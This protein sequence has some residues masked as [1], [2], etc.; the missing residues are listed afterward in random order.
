MR[1]VRA[2]VFPPKAERYIRRPR[3]VLSGGRLDSRRWLQPSRERP[4]SRERVLVGARPVDRRDR[5]VELAQVHRQLT[6][7][8]IPVVEHDRAQERDR[9]ASRRARARRSSCRQFRISVRVVHAAERRLRVGDALVER[10]H[11][12]PPRSPGSDRAELRRL[13]PARA[14][15]ASWRRAP[16]TIA[17]CSASSPSVR[18]LACGRQPSCVVGNAL[19]HAARRLRLPVRAPAACR[20][21]SSSASSFRELR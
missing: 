19:E 12:D 11:A 4:D 9:A 7:V 10:R 15:A 18:A 14:A 6:A 1:P 21:S 13:A 5:H 16:G 17:T 2:L 8:V 3:L 20:R